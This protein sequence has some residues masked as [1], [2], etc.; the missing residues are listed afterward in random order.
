MTPTEASTPP[1]GYRG[2]ISSRPFG[3]ERVPQH[4]QQLVIRDYAARNGLLFLL[5]ATEYAMPESTMMLNQ[6][7]DELHT[8]RGVILYS[9]LQLPEDRQTRRSLFGRVL[10]AGAELHGALESLPLRTA[11]DARRIE[12]IL[13]LH[14]AMR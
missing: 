7:M 12:D 3:G 2:Y 4:V 11:D 5:S 8:V 9:F 14:Q 10:D 1:Q 13:L 6:V